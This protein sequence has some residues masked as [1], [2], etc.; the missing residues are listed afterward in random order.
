MLDTPDA[1]YWTLELDA[2]DRILELATWMLGALD[3]EDAGCWRYWMPEILD[4]GDIGYWRYWMLE[5]WMLR[6]P[7]VG[8]GDACCFVIIC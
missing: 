3:D 5:K 2:G 6:M 4:A 8:A 1:G 7:G